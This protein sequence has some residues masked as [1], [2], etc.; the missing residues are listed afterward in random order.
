MAIIKK[1]LIIAIFLSLASPAF[2]STFKINPSSGTFK[3]GCTSTVDIIL[4]AGGSATNAAD[5]IIDYDP[6]QTEV[7]QIKP[8]TV[9][10][11]YFG[12]V[13]DSTNGVL[14]LTGASFSGTFNSS[15]VFAT[16]EFK[17]KNSSGSSYF[18]IRFTGADPYN[19]LDS[20]I[21]DAST[22][23]DDLTSIQNG[24]F[25]FSS[26]ACQNDTTPPTINF[27]SPVNNQ[28]NVPANANIQVE[29]TDSGSGVN[30]STVQIVINGVSYDTS[31][32]RV[33]VTG[34]NADYQITVR[35]YDPLFTSQTDTVLVKASDISG[36]SKQD[37]INFNIPNNSPTPTPTPTAGPT[38]TPT[39]G[40]TPTVT[41]TPT[42]TLG[43]TTI[44]TPN[45]TATPFICPSAP[46]CPATCSLIPTSFPKTGPDTDSP[47][48]EF[49]SPL[50]KGE[51][52][53]IPQ[54]IIRFTDSGAGID[55]N[56][57]KISFDQYIYT[58]IDSQFSSSGGPTSYLVKVKLDKTFPADSQHNITAFASDLSGNGIS[59]SITTHTG[60][61]LAGQVLEFIYP[62][63]T[64]K[65]QSFNFLPFILLALAI[66]PAFYFLRRSTPDNTTPLGYIF[67]SKT[68][69]PIA[70]LPVSI[71]DESNKNIK[72]VKTNVFG[73]F[74][75]TL[76]PGKYK[77]TPQ[78]PFY[79]F[80]SATQ[81]PLN[82]PHPYFGQ[83]TSDYQAIPVDLIKEPPLSLLPKP[84]L[85]TNNQ[86]QL[87][88]GMTLGLKEIKFNSLIAT[89]ITNGQGQ[90]RFLVPNGHY[91]LIDIDH[92]DKVL[93]TIDTRQRVD[94][95]T[96]INQNV[97]VATRGYIL[98]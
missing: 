73:I 61:T 51:V 66:V 50:D 53:P 91:Q 56:S 47:L 81:N 79:R 18:N 85:V 20:N 86:N 65:N 35:P 71:F 59:Q 30:I 26:G 7:V 27:Q 49:I 57:I 34:N 23:N 77:F 11:N 72:V 62:E 13:V 83:I 95:Y 15:G 39:S 54:I 5:I 48:V 17:P 19:T 6:L 64:K 25:S 32:P 12:N 89:R 36:N 3:Q 92:Q 70:N 29:I 80:P 90:Y 10:G 33:T 38:P 93:A 78:S 37:S 2:A 43:P 28:Q 68:R 24:T 16:I 22:S 67:D 58:S 9:Y 8:G 84:G 52:D 87:Q 82:H 60:R 88:A 75:A 94:G 74:S 21:A 63:A 96:T 40:P 41:P 44:V 14:R 45:P 1:F 31:S 76:P 42:K 55:L 97:Q 98:K 69:E 4:D 46:T